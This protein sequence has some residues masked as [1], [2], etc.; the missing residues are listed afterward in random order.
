MRESSG[1]EDK[2][3]QVSASDRTTHIEPR[4]HEDPHSDKLS[5][6]IESCRRTKAIQKR[7]SKRVLIPLA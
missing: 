2:E 1:R 4:D 7:I 5:P 3:D 6:Q